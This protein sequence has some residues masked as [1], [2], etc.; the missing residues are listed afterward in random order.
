MTKLGR[1]HRAETMVHDRDPFG[2]EIFWYG[3][4]GHH[5]SDEPNTDFTAI[6]EGYISITP[7]SLDMT[8]QRHTDTLTD[9]L[10]QQK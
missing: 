9:W 1:R 3:P 7:L 4:I 5:A 6:H 2:S 8:A 10:E